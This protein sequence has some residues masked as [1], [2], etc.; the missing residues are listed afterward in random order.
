V[1]ICAHPLS[2]AEVR[3]MSFAAAAWHF[4]GATQITQLHFADLEVAQNEGWKRIDGNRRHAK[5][6]CEPL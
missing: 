4:L 6:T 2:L 1:S 5:F 3:S